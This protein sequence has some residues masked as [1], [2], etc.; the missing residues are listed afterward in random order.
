MQTQ[1]THLGHD[2]HTLGVNGTDV[3]VREKTDEV[4]LSGL[5]ESKDSMALEPHVASDF[6]RDLTDHPLKGQLANKELRALL[7]AP[8]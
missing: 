6:F 2:G 1:N 3:G 4:R 8:N 5:L 7:E